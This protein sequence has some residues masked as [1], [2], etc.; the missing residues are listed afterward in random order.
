MTGTALP[1]G[2]NAPG[3]VFVGRGRSLP[4]DAPDPFAVLLEKFVESS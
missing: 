1:L 4:E 2:A 3:I